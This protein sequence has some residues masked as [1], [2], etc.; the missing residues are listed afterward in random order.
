MLYVYLLKETIPA[1]VLSLFGFPLV[2]LTG[3]ILQLMELFVNKGVPLGLRSRVARGSKSRAF[4]W[5]IGILLIYYLLI[6]AGTSLAERGI[7]LLEVGM[8]AP[9]LIFLT[10]GIRLLVKAANENPV[11]IFVGVQKGIEWVRLKRQQGRKVPE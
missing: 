3:R 9:H 7:L 5:S 1:F 8:W 6:N 2:L 11:L 4:S 10:L